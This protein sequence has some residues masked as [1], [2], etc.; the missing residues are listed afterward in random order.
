MQIHSILARL[1]KAFDVPFTVESDANQI[2]RDAVG[3][4]SPKSPSA[5]PRAPTAGGRDGG[6]M[7]RPS[8]LAMTERT[9]EPAMKNG[10][11]C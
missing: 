2:W 6:P 7:S 9:E 3:S 5:R 8:P 4:R 10:D 1:C 11:G